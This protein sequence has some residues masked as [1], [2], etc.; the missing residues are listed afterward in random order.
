[1]A[2]IRG[3]MPNNYQQW[4]PGERLSRQISD[5]TYRLSGAAAAPMDREE[6][7][8]ELAWTVFH[9][10]KKVPSKEGWIRKNHAGSD[11]TEKDVK[12]YLVVTGFNVTY[13]KGYDTILEKPV[14]MTGH[15]DL[16][17][18][19]RLKPTSDGV[20]DD[21]AVELGIVEPGR[22]V[23]PKLITIAF[24][25]H[26]E[27]AEWLQYLCSAIDP[28]A[29][30]DDDDPTTPNFFSPFVDEELQDTL[31]RMC[32]KQ[33]CVSAYLALF[34]GRPVKV[35]PI[36]KRSA[37]PIK[38]HNHRKSIGAAPPTDKVI[39]EAAY[40][41]DDEEPRYSNSA[42]ALSSKES[43]RYSNRRSLHVG[44]RPEL[45][46]MP[47]V[48]ESEPDTSTGAGLGL[49]ASSAP[50]SA[51][52]GNLIRAL[53]KGVGD[54]VAGA[55]SPRGS[56]ETTPTKAKGQRRNS[57]LKPHTKNGKNALAVLEA[58]GADF[59]HLKEAEEAAEKKLA[60]RRKSVTQSETEFRK[61]ARKHAL[62][63]AKSS[64]S[65]IGDEA[66]AAADSVHHKLDEIAH[67]LDHDV[68][69]D[70]IVVDAKVDGQHYPIGANLW[71]K[72][73]DGS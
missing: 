68:P 11:F 71:V 72:R 5:M 19:V 57:L 67:A 39:F 28:E 14:S 60:G 61:E 53:S 64:S 59:E 41:K 29:M 16:R 48:E 42:S 6:E 33:P 55:L 65:G 27:R 62:E 15:F 45:A 21:Q 22:A 49:G 50:A 63:L 24:T 70:D 31:N 7:A 35:E 18:V 73:S 47:S 26:D 4:V 69:V 52:A 1:M 58:K 17:N 32:A 25:R 20:D 30:D 46:T 56:V 54:F 36:S 38:K 23:P 43:G 40:H 12:R 37:P 13:Y 8:N 44:A 2:S 3:A 66:V 10:P 9:G 51:P 34:G